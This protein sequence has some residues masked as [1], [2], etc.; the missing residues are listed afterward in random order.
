[1]TSS[2]ARCPGSKNENGL[3]LFFFCQLA[4]IFLIAMVAQSAV[5]L[6]AKHIVGVSPPYRVVLSTISGTT[7]TADTLDTTHIENPQF[8][9]DGT[10]FA[11]WRNKG[12]KWCLSVYTLATR[13]FADLIDCAAW[14]AS[15]TL[16][17]GVEQICWPA[18]D[19]IYAEKPSY[20][21][22]IYKINCTDPTQRQL[23]VD[24][25]KF[26]AGYRLYYFYCTPDV[27]LAGITLGTSSTG[28]WNAWQP[29]HH[30]PPTGDPRN[31]PDLIFELQ[32]CNPALSP[33]GMWAERFV[34]GM[35]QGEIIYYWNA[36]Q[37]TYAYANMQGCDNNT[38]T[39][40]TDPRYCGCA[41]INIS[42]HF[43]PWSGKTGWM[44]T[45]EGPQWAVNSDRWMSIRSS[46]PTNCDN[47][48][49]G[50]NACVYSWTD[51]VFLNI[52]NHP[53]GK[54]AL[55]GGSLFVKGGPANSLQDVNGSWLNYQTKLPVSVKH[56]TTSSLFD[57]SATAKIKTVDNAVRIAINQPGDHAVSLLDARGIVLSCTRGTGIG[58]YSVPEKMLGSGIFFVKIAAGGRDETVRMV[59]P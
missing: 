22:Q 37:N 11:C 1:M 34:D 24:Y 20:S 16:V 6:E 59:R 32:N 21:A 4:A 3:R 15:P 54:T 43:E 52:T 56:Q 27:K 41:E 42:Q 25:G 48:S 58:E 49:A 53:N 12:G 7:V 36:A 39:H 10:K 55:S 8:N 28:G 29:I 33:S 50:S 35:H 18:G 47:Y 51:K 2:N 40:C 17:R 46:M 57:Q 26:Q 13:S 44:C 23:V 5:A 31:P 9:F 14:G 38:Y 30:F 19:W 45:L